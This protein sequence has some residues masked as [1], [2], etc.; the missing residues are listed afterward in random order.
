M[1]LT[2]TNALK[3]S[4]GQGKIADDGGT[5]VCPENT[6]DIHNNCVDSFVFAI[7]GSVVGVILVGIITFFYMRHKNNKRGK[8]VSAT[9]VLAMRAWPSMI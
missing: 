7:V 4:I 2:L 8:S 3:P 1:I 9:W 5:C 6:F